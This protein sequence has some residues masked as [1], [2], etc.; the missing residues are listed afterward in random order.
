MM[1]EQKL[2]PPRVTMVHILA[3]ILLLLL[4]PLAVE[5]ICWDA[6]FVDTYFDHCREPSDWIGPK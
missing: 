4:I 1:P 2:P 3:I 6:P 5:L